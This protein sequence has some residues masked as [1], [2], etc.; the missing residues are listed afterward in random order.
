MANDALRTTGLLVSP[1]AFERWGESI[2]EAAAGAGLALDPVMLPADPATRLGPDELD[3]IDIAFFSHDIFPERSRQFFA[4]AQGAPRLRWMQLQNAGID[5]PVFGRLLEKGVRLTTSSGTTAVPLAHNAIAGVLALARRLPAAFEAQRRRAWEPGWDAPA[6]RDLPGQTMVIVGLG[7]IGAEIAKL[8]R[9][10]GLHVLG[11]R[12]SAAAPGDPVDEMHPPSALPELL[13]R[14]DWIVLT[15]PLTPETEGLIGREALAALPQGAH[16]VNVAR[17]AIVDEPALIDAL[18]TGK[19][20]GAY[21]DVFAEEPLPDA[22]PLWALPNVIITPHNSSASEGN[23][24]RIVEL[25][26]DNL[27]RWAADEPLRNEATAP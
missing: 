8:A 15:L 19:L 5:N 12:R 22:S 25:F 3:R 23:A 26:V 20:A 16:L 1:L 24:G 9:T 14:A 7:A 11:V 6:P 4:A 17:G 2:A 21:L 27:R 10:L 13:P 18:A